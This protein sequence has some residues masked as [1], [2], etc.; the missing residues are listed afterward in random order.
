MG[1]ARLGAYPP[2]PLVNPPDTEA[3]D[4]EAADTEAADTE[5]DLQRRQTTAPLETTVPVEQGA[6]LGKRA[7]GRG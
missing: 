5:A 7:P 3:A 1:L 2:V 6:R 4:T